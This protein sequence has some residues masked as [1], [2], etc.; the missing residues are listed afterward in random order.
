MLESIRKEEEKLRRPETIVS[1]ER[2]CDFFASRIPPGICDTRTLESWARQQKHSTGSSGLELGRD[3]LISE[4]VTEKLRHDFPDSLAVRNTILRIDYRFEPGADLDGSTIDVPLEML[5]MLSQSDLDWAV[6]GTLQERSLFL[7]KNL[8]KQLRKL[9]VPLPDFIDSF[10]AWRESQPGNEERS[11]LCNQL[12]E[13]ARRNRGIRLDEGVLEASELPAHLQPWIRVLDDAGKELA[14]SQ[15]LGQLQKQFARS[16]VLKLQEATAHPLET[17]QIKDWNFGELPQA[18][19]VNSA[20]GLQKYPALVD[21]GD[22]ASLLLQDDASIAERLTRQGLCRLV[23]LRSVQQRALIQSRLKAVAGK[24]PVLSLQTPEEIQ[25][26]G[27]TIIFRQAFHLDECDI[28]RCKDA[29][30]KLL[31]EGKPRLIAT[32]EKFETLVRRIVDGH[33]ELQR[34]L[35][36]LSGKPLEPA[37]KDIRQQL[38]G[39]LSTGY[40]SRIPGPWLQELP[41]YLQAIGLRL[42]KLSGQLARDQ[43]NQRLINALEARRRTVLARCAE[44]ELP[45]DDTQWLLEELRVS[46]FAQTLG[47]R[48]PVSEKRISK[49]LEELERNLR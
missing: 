41:R 45:L 25:K 4:A 23:I 14:R 34:R 49:R 46:L 12:R 24:L 38:Q 15:S 5:G 35:G 29:F 3:D 10:L 40:L 48:M 33:F 1:E 21:K 32:A 17:E 16:A 26:E 47:T 7:M 31:M 2:V 39:L 30:E 42:D 44:R 22:S 18:I 36:T 9:F 13:F 6:P 8:P 19:T 28:P 20:T 43:E 37:V 11:S 27:L